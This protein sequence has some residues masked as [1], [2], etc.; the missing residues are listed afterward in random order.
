[1]EKTHDVRDPCPSGSWRK[2]A[3]ERSGYKASERAQNGQHNPGWNLSKEITTPI[4]Q[5]MNA[6]LK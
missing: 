2:L 3:N 1:M 4:T 5:D 6:A